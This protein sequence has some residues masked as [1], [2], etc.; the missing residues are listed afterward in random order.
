MA[1]KTGNRRGRHRRP[2]I[3]PVLRPLAWSALLSGVVAFAFATPVYADPALPTT[4]PDTGSRP[5]VVGSLLLP[6]ATAPAGGTGPTAPLPPLLNG[7][8]ATQIQAKETQLAVLG[9][10]LLQLRQDRDTAAGL[11]VTAQTQWQSAHEQL[12]KAQQAADVAAAEAFKEA[13]GLPP[14]ALGSDL[15]GLGALSRLQKGAPAGADSIAPARELTRARA[16]EQTARE[17]QLA[18]DA[19][20]ATATTLFTTKETTFKQ[21]EA[22][23]LKLKRD[24]ADQL[25]AIERAREAA[26]QQLGPGSLNS[27]SVAGMVADPRALQAVQYALAQRGDPYVWAAEGPN[28]FDCSGLMWAAYRSAGYQLPRVAKDQYYAT[29]ARA[30]DRYSLLPGD[31]IFFASGSSWTTVHHVGMYIGGGKMVHAP[32]SGDVVKVS[33]VWWSR[34]YAATRIYGAVPAPTTTPNPTPTTTRPTPKP[35]ATTPTPKPTATTPTPK[36]TTPTPTP[37]PTTPTPTPKP[38]TGSPDPT[39]GTGTPTTPGTPPTSTPPST[40]PSPTPNPTTGSTP[41]A[42]NNVTPSGT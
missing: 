36:P 24:N 19:R 27:D 41:S 22:D 39:T 8:L 6:G 16:A 40:A 20:V 38:T 32:N 23:L 3:S 11:L 37:K 4:V 1:Q 21:L 15:E 34:F 13:A 14:G 29:R 25:A 28:E 42:S 2:L 9:D 18:A 33:T 10:E 17:G 12:L 26:E 30:V 35:T 5:A 7:P 31:L